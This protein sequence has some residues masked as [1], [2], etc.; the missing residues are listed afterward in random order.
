MALAPWIEKAV[1]RMSEDEREDLSL[2]LLS[3]EMQGE[4]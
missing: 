4:V 2:L 3:I 1:S